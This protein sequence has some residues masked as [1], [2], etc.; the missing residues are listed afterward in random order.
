MPVKK[1]YKK[2]RPVVRK[3]KRRAKPSR[4]YANTTVVKSGRGQPFPERLFTKLRSV[5][6][7]TIG[8]AVVSQVISMMGGNVLPTPFDAI[9]SLANTDMSTYYTS[10]A[11]A[12]SIPTTQ[13]QGYAQY[14]T[15]YKYY[16]IHACKIKVTPLNVSGNDVGLLAIAPMT[17]AAASLMGLQGT[18][19]STIPSIPQ[20][21]QMPYAKSKQFT[22]YA[23][24]NTNNAV[25][26]FMTTAQINGL[27]KLQYKASV[28][29]GVPIANAPSVSAG[30][31]DTDFPWSFFVGIQDYTG[32]FGSQVCVK[33]ELECYVE[34]NQPFGNNEN[35]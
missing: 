19:T 24:S 4:K 7:T 18:N 12:E 13:Y 6:D 26:C 15:I 20:L 16:R 21:S 14:A 8:A 9:G 25:S 33:V 27:S 31:Q 35:A 11:G 28:T 22:T 30:L 5:V 1:S 10:I 17:Y 23:N 34:F 3:A 29:A 32:Q 2:K